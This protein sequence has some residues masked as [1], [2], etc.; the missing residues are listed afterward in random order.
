MVKVYAWIFGLALLILFPHF[1]TTYLQSIVIKMLI[2]AV[3]AMSLNIL[4]GYAG[5]FSLGHAAYFGFGGYMAGILIVHFN[6]Q[7]IWLSGGLSILF[8]AILAALLAI[9]ALRVTG[10]YFLFV[11][12]A[13]GQLLYSVAIKW[14]SVT[15][16]SNGLTG[17]P[18]PDFGIPGLETGPISFYY[19]VCVISILCFFLIYM[20]IKSPFGRALQGVGENPSRMAALGYNVWLYKYLGFIIGGFFAGVSGVMFAHFTGVIAPIHL[21]VVTSTLAMLMVIIGG[22]RMVFGPLIGAAFIVLLDHISS[23]FLPERWPLVLGAVF[24]L[25]VMFI[26]DGISVYGLRIYRRITNENT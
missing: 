9:P 18:F 6:I 26:P 3:F 22:C 25:A 4:W 11:T 19:F 24:V 14:R 13:M 12:L 10:A 23:L 5:L 1:T 8:T 2:Y 15:G 20:I 16:G 17:I 21:G 7:H